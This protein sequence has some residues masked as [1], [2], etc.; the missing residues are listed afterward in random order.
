MKDG[1]RLWTKEETILAINLYCKIPFGQ[2]HGRNADVIE[3]SILINRTPGSVARKLGNLASL[4]PK[5]KQRGIGGLPNTS[6]LDKEVWAEYMYDWDTEFFDGEQLLA[7]KLETTIEKRY[8]ID[9]ENLPDIQGKEKERLVKSRVNQSIFRKIVLSN[10]NNRCCITCIQ[11]PELLVASHISP[12]SH[13]KQNQLNPKNGLSLNTLHDRAF[14]Q[15]LISITEDLKI[16]ISP[17][18]KKYADV[19]S[20]KQNFIDYDGQSII[21]PQKFDPGPSFLKIY[22]ERFWAKNSLISD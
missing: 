4:D 10:Y 22:N 20:V 17:K 9:L 1:Q 5:L 3:L 16:I 7:Q 14:D 21:A 2:M 8:N 13:D 6:K 11:I 15:H 18:F 19:L 12:W